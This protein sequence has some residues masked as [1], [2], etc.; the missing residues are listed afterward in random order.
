M[1]I[2][3]FSTFSP[4]IFEFIDHLK[5]KRHKKSFCVEKYECHLKYHIL[6]HSLQKN[7]KVLT[8]FDVLG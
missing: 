2:S 1:E 6:T 7:C 8:I 5:K 3:H 4:I